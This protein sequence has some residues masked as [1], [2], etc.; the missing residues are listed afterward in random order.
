VFKQNSAGSLH[1]HYFTNF[2]S[3]YTCNCMWL[4]L[5]SAFYLWII[6]DLLRVSLLLYKPLIAYPHG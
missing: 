3:N 6:Y 2:I 5:L 4:K 1:L